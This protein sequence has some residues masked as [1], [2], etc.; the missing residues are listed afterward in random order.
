VEV[1]DT[2][3]DFVQCAI[4]AKA[5]GYDGIYL[6]IYEYLSMYQYVYVYVYVSNY[7]SI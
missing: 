6:S 4:Y 5:A 7:L 1:K 3:K 2:I